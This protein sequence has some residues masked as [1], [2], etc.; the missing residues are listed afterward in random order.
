MDYERKLKAAHE[1]LNNKGVWKSNYNPPNDKLLKMIGC[2]QPP[3]YYRSFVANVS[4]S[5]IS[6]TP[7]YGILMWLFSWG[8]EGKSIAEAVVWSSI[9]GTLFGTTMALYFYIQHKR[10]KLT[11]WKSLGGE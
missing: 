6:F 7:I 9:A 10:L 1:E 3:P 8:S 2:K 11:D 4:L 5:F